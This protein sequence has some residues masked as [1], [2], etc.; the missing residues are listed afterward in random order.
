MK[1]LKMLG[2][3]GA[4]CCAAATCAAGDLLISGAG[5]ATTTDDG[6]IVLRVTE[7][8]T[9][10]VTGSGTAWV[11]VVGGGGGGGILAGGGGGGGQVV[12]QKAVALTA[13]SYQIVVGKGGTGAT[14]NRV[15]EWGLGKGN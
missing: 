10:N 11:V 6:D 15:T 13:G 12:E 3:L 8:G 2:S 14:T 7:S 9:L 1:K 4:A 5:E